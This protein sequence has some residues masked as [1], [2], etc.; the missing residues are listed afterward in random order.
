MSQGLKDRIRLDSD[1]RGI[2]LF[3]DYKKIK[4][5]IGLSD[6]F[7]CDSWGAAGQRS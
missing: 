1:I 5:L 6:L 4:Y 3:G 2:I 7:P